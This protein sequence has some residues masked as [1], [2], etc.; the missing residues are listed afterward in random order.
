MLPA[1][2]K[3]TSTHAGAPHCPT[4]T[5]SVP[6]SVSQFHLFWICSPQSLQGHSQSLIKYCIYIHTDNFWKARGMLWGLLF[7]RM[8][9]NRMIAHGNLLKLKERS[10]CQWPMCFSFLSTGNYWNAASFPNPSSYLHFST[11][12][13]ETSADI[14]FYFKTLIPQGVFLENLGNT[15]FI[16][17]EL[18]CEYKIFINSC[19]SFYAGSGPDC[20]CHWSQTSRASLPQEQ[21]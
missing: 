12:Q 18:K 1:P 9:G 11:F 6:R 10:W 7:H 15:D 13:G 5:H 20:K 3:G 8:G 21:C 16:K 17:L 14:S 19:H 4:T 2:T